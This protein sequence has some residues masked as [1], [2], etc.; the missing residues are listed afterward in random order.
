MS[1]TRRPGPRLTSRREDRHIVRNARVQPT[2]SSAAIQA[3]VEPSLGAPVSSRAIPSRLAEEHLESRYPLHVLPLTLTHRR[4][5]LEWCRPRGNWTAAE[6]NQ[7]V[8]SDESRFNL[9]SDDNRVRVWRAC[10]ERLNPVFAVRRHTAPTVGVMVWSG[11]AYNTW[12]PLVLIRITPY[13]L[14][15]M[16]LTFCNHMCCHSCNGS[17]ESFFNKTM[18]ELI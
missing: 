14:S 2:A 6:W 4:L 18:L 7:V 12:S 8:F 13:Q 5:R 9:S 1:F 17:Q 16:S 10:G 15:D 3:Q 11:N